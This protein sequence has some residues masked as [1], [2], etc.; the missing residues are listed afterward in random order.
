MSKF[1]KKLDYLQLKFSK[2]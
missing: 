2:F 1:G